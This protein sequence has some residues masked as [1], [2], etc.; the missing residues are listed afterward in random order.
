M[1]ANFYC[2]KKQNLL[3]RGLLSLV[4]ALV[5]FAATAQVGVGTTNPN[6]SAQIHIV[7]E[8]KGILIPQVP[9]THSTDTTTI[10]NGNVESLLV[11]NTNTQNDVFP[12]YYYWSNNRWNRLTSIDLGGIALSNQAITELV[13]NGDGTITYI[14]ELGLPTIINLA[15]GSTG[16]SAYQIAVNNG[17]V[18]TE[19]EWLASLQG[20]NGVDGANGIDGLSAYQIAVNNGFVGTEVEWLASLQ[21]INGVDGANGIDGL[22]AYQIAVNNGFSGTEAQW[23]ASLQGANGADGLSA[24]QIAVN[25]GFTGTET[26]WLASLQGINGVDGANG[27]DGLSAY[28]IAVN[29]G[30]TGT[31]TQ[32]LVSLQGTNGID[33]LSA[34][35]IA[36][37]NGFSG[38]E[39]EWLAS[40]QGAN[41]A[42][43]VA[44]QDG[45]DGLSAYQIAVNNGFS[46]TEV[47]WLASLQGSDANIWL[48]DGTNTTVE[49]VSSDVGTEWKV[50]VATANG[51]NLGV[52]K[53]AENNPTVSIDNQGSLS[54]NLEN[55]NDI[56]EITGAYEAQLTD[57]ILLG[58]A[59]TADV[60]V[61]LPSPENNKGKTFT[62]KK[63]DSN[64]DYYVNVYGNINGLSQLYTALPYSGWVLVSDG[65]QWRITNKF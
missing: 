23:L 49:S 14:N 34:Y 5:T 8:D 36:V 32:W 45:V 19:V 30:F 24:Y 48:V 53:E 21:G 2:R 61:I 41:G 58:N 39:A 55:L 26:Q 12:G 46:G 13:D 56:K 40:L 17:F 18:G 31:E 51:T 57:V 7:A 1:K 59:S 54:V 3:K 4:F 52:V 11:Y 43:G 37:N 47:E 62:I 9:L 29:N 6:P 25:N 50:N 15:T 28:Q 63:Q 16:L 20:I 35:Q 33:G 38:T 60:T 10:T 44:G 22:S 27:I 64:E 42:D 65:T